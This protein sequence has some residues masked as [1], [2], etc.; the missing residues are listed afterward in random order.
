MKIVEKNIAGW[1]YVRASDR[2]K[3]ISSR[4]GVKVEIKTINFIEVC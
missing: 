4:E 1:Q 2:E 3:R